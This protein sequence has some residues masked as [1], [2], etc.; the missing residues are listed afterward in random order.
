MRT[1]C[2][3]LFALPCLAQTPPTIS[4][5]PRS[6]SASLGATVTFRVTASG[7]APL[8]YQWHFKTADI[9]GAKTNSLVLSNLTVAHAGE[10]FVTITNSAGFT[11]SAIAVLTVDTNFI[12]ITAGFFATDG[13]DSSGC[14]WGD[15]DNDGFP[16]LFVGNGS[17]PNYLYHNNRDGTFT[18]MTNAPTKDT[19]YGGSWADYDND[20][21]LDLFIGAN[22]ANRLY[23]NNGDGTFTRVTN[24]PVP[25]GTVSWSGS[26]GDY[27]RDG[28][29]D[30]FISNGGGNNN[31]LLHNNR[32]GTFTKI[33]AGRIVSDGG[34]S[35]GATWQDYDN[36]GWPDLYVANNGGNSF[37]YRNLGNGTFARILSGSVATD[38]QNAIVPDWG[39]YD[40]DGWP[41]LAVG[42]IGRNLLYRNLRGTNWLKQTT[43][44]LVTD[45]VN[46]EIVQ[47]ADYDNDGYI[48][49][50]S[51]NANNQN[52]TLYHN[53]RDGT[54]TKI[55]TG[56]VVSD[57][58]NSAGSAWGD[59][60]NDGFID[61]FVANWQGSRP[62]FFYRNAGNANHWL[63]VKCIGRVS[64]RAG[65]GAK[66][67]VAAV[68]W[69]KDVTQ[70]REIS[71][72]LGFGQSPLLAHF[73]MGDAPRAKLITIEWL[74]G[75]VQELRDIPVDQTINITEPPSFDSPAS[76][77][78][79]AATINL[80]GNVG[81][82][83]DIE[84]SADFSSWQS[85]TTVTN[86]NRI[87]TLTV[88]ISGDAAR[89]FI[90]AKSL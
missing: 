70:L 25:T 11:N 69:N 84:T 13:G 88:P 45:S 59:Y 9:E 3:L 27:D 21:Y 24:F 50:F 90:R 64:N 8:N 76:S 49:I 12:K 63:K 2:L 66:V 16:E 42:C 43:G 4:T 29:V 80:H 72:G 62:N 30:L 15:I 44:P 73:G 14:A 40:N 46:S 37:L 20:G 34:A 67:R 47:W 26:W 57:G 87:S 61:L 48:D 38:S 7:T 55:T 60:D 5:Q 83:F 81:D 33:T 71:G 31:F 53:N 39:D 82:V 58:G 19:G 78:S 17:T 1:L 10:Y 6:Q 35:I 86:T 52:N 75:I 41:D 22:S 56:S 23:H 18:K 79:S 74:G 85:L 54:F 32:N 89:I 28:W 77:S 68:L 51:A 65:I 36:D